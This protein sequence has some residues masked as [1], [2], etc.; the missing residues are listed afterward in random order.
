ASRVQVLVE[1][2]DV[3]DPAPCAKIEWNPQARQGKGAWRLNWQA[4]FTAA[5]PYAL[6]PFQGELPPPKKNESVSVPSAAC[7]QKANFRLTIRCPEDLWTQVEPAVWAWVNF[8]GLGSRTRRGCGAIKG[9]EVEVD[10]GGSILRTIKE[11]A[12]KD[13]ADL[14]AMWKK[15]V[16][17]PY[18]VREWPTMPSQFLCHPNSG[19]LFEQWNRVIG[20]LRD[21]RQKAGGSPGHPRPPG[22][23][24][25]WYPEPDTIRR[26][27]GDCSAGH[28]PSSHLS[29]GNPLPDGFP[30]AEFGLPIVFKFIDD[31]N[32]D[33]Q[34]TT[35]HPYVGG[36]AED[37]GTPR[38]PDIHI[39]GGEIKD[40]MASPLI[41][42]PLALAT[43]GALAVILPMQTS[44]VGHVAIVDESGA[45]RTPR[46]TV[47]IRDATLVGYPDS[48]IRGLSTTGSALEAFLNLAVLSAGTHGVHKDT[49][50]RRI[51]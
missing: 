8:G 7:I 50:Y 37:R 34:R 31:K 51:P 17:K 4:P 36:T 10:E 45:D 19:K 43:D 28:D 25:S 46:H 35:L 1:V 39:T 14:A 2:I 33:P 48:P 11:L 26:I 16:P 20:L 38:S 49:G 12:P 40:R 27:T 29:G 22:P 42:K 3:S 9:R 41:L 15:Y 13:A 32:G 30:R 18:P 21:F 5:L 6:F 47:P 24:R 23:D 44:G